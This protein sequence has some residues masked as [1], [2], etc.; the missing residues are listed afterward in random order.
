MRETFEEVYSKHYQNSLSQIIIKFV[1]CPKITSNVC[2]L[3]QSI[4]PPSSPQGNH[5]F[6]LTALPLLLLEDPSYHASVRDLTEKL[7]S[8]Y[9]RFKQSEEGVNFSGDVCVVSDCISSLMVYDVLTRP[10]TP[11]LPGHAHLSSSSNH[12]DWGE[13]GRGGGG[14]GGQSPGAI[15]SASVPSGSKSV[16][17][18][19]KGDGTLELPGLNRSPSSLFSSLVFNVSKFFTFGSPLGLVLLLKRL[20]GKPRLLVILLYFVA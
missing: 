3:L 20:R 11:L 10:S 6:P 18:V 14:G 2:D 1:L 4:Q 13:E 15:R 5:N 7:N 12:L 9:C 16:P 8:I 17:T 19:R